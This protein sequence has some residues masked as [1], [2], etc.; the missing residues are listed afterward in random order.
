MKNIY[1]VTCAI[2]LTSCQKSFEDCVLEN[3][4]GANSDI[5]AINIRRACIE[6]YGEPAYITR[7]KIKDLSEVKAPP[8]VADSINNSPAQQLNKNSSRDKVINGFQSNLYPKEV[9][10][11][12]SELK[13]DENGNTDKII[14]YEDANGNALPYE[15]SDHIE[16]APAAEN[17]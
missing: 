4:K 7:E 1:I 13:T 11:Y 6:K 14:N 8:V 5:A 9:L 12:A 17:K 2:L 15:S 10:P 3:M 16:E